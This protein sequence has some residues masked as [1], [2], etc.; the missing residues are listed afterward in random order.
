MQDIFIVHE[1]ILYDGFGEGEDKT[2]IES[3]EK[4]LNACGDKN[5]EKGNIAF[6]PAEVFERIEKLCEGKKGQELMT[7]LKML[8]VIYTEKDCQGD[9]K[10]M[11][12]VNLASDF[13]I[14]N[15]VCIV[16]TNGKF[17]Q[18]VTDEGYLFYVCTPNEAIKL[19][20]D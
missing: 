13:C 8:N 14:K 17:N 3:A 19:M 9:N 12:Y 10:K 16:S 11:P 4:F 6:F 20:I 18:W 2:V 7:F 5:Y 1:S 15:K